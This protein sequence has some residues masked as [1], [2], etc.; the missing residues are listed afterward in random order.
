MLLFLAL[1]CKPPTQPPVPDAP[2]AW[3]E[4]SPTD[5]DYARA[6]LDKAVQAEG[7]GGTAWI[8][9]AYAEHFCMRPFTWVPDIEFQK[10]FK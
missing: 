6:S 3:V 2:M 10:N 5:P 1:S 4:L 7:M 8:I 9:D